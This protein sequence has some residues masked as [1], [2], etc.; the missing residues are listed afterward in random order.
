MPSM[1]VVLQCAIYASFV[2][3]LLHVDIPMGSC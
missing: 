1:G 3:V 2:V